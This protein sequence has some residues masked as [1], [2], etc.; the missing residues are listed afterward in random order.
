MFEV[1]LVPDLLM[2]QKATIT[3]TTV[4]VSTKPIFECCHNIFVDL[5]QQELSKKV[6]H[7][8]AYSSCVGCNLNIRVIKEIILIDDDMLKSSKVSVIGPNGFEELR[9]L[10]KQGEDFCKEITCVLQERS[11]LEFHYAK[12]LNKL[13][14]KIT[15]ASKDAL[16]TTAQTWLES[17]VVMARESEL[18]RCLAF[19]LTEDVVKPLKMLVDAHYKTRKQI[20]VVVDRISKS[21]TDRR[22][23][24]A[25]SL[26]QS[27]HSTKENEKL[28]EHSLESRNSKGKLVTDK[29]INKME[30][31]R[32]KAQE[33]VARADQE[34]YT[35][36]LKAERARQEWEST[37]FKANIQ[38]QKLEEERLEHMQDLVQK[39]A[40]HISV[41][42]P[43]MIQGC[44]ILNAAVS[45]IDVQGDIQESIRSRGTGPNSPEQFLP[46]FYSENM[47]NFMNAERRKESLQKFFYML[48]HDI[49]M[50]RKG[51]EGVQNLGRAFSE[52]PN[53]GNE[54]AQQDVT[55][56]LHQLHTTLAYL[57]A[58]R[59]KVE[60][61]LA[62][63]NGR[64]RP[65]HPLTAHMKQYSDKQ[66]SVH[67]VLTL[68]DG[69]ITELFSGR[70][71][72]GLSSSS[73]WSSNNDF[74]EADRGVGDGTSV[75][76]GNFDA[77]FNHISE[78]QNNIQSIQSTNNCSIG[79][80]QALYSYQAIQNDEL[81]IHTGDLITILEKTDVNW[82]K[83]ELDGLVGLFPS[84]YIKEL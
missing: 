84:T 18:H 69:G 5:L 72:Q 24:E 45:K 67:S 17:A 56:K 6:H 38:F 54:D 39:Y 51:I 23:E 28:Q 11:D 77:V 31:K 44:E 71:D 26:K 35:S 78:V 83:G 40:N 80:C 10:V 8:H 61:A 33:A 41:L 50:E 63:L 62:D 48:N 37:V 3:I 58:T 55:Q 12:S 81:T 70:S 60:C 53:F 59:H 9:K 79:Q 32:R 68:P 16:G 15:K 13:S 65:A 25:K 46:D 57:E 42:G 27:Y 66:G 7:D 76:E 22:N 29:D 19:G 30:N 14:A 64:S 52:T 1:K 4:L 43:E 36:C 73:S 74:G 34:Y 47:K 2:W 75:I 49:E 82:W 21:L 20:E